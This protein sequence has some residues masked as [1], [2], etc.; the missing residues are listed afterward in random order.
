MGGIKDATG[1]YAGGFLVLAT[2]LLIEAALVLS[3]RLPD[4]H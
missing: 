4:R 1:G 2:S 3:L